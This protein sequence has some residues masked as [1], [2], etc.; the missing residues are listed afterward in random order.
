MKRW[1]LLAYLAGLAVIGVA[2]FLVSGQEARQRQARQ[3]E[4]LGE[5]AVGISAEADPLP[6]ARRVLRGLFPLIRG[7][8]VSGK[9]TRRRLAHLVRGLPTD[10]FSLF[11]TDERENL[12]WAS[13]PDPDLWRIARARLGAAWLRPYGL[14]VPVWR[15]ARPGKRPDILL[16]WVSAPRAPP[17]SPLPMGHGHPAPRTPRPCTPS[18]A[19]RA[20]LRTRS[21][22]R[23]WR[24]RSL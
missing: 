8:P 1:L 3:A 13:R 24:S 21:A 4:D 9:E 19:R 7:R 5:R 15:H 17:P 12:L 6:F 22:Q 14:P 2:G 10:G 16:V 23:T 20:M 11:L 18:S